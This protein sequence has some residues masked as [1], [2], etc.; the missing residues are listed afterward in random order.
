M[1]WDNILLVFI[2]FCRDGF[3]RSAW[4][5]LFCDLLAFIGQ[6]GDEE[7][8]VNDLVELVTAGVFEVEVQA[9]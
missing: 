5:A 9:V 3:D 4:G 6:V 8:G 2:D 1:V 7:P